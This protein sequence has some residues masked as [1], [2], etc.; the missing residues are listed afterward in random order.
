MHAGPEPFEDRHDLGGRVSV[1]VVGADADECDLRSD[2]GQEL[3]DGRS[4]A[5][6]RDRQQ[7]RAQGGG[8]TRQQ[9]RLRR[10]LDVARGEHTLAVVLD[11]QHDRGVVQLATG[12]AV[13]PSR[14]RMEHVD[15]QI[16]ERQRLARDRRADR[17]VG[18]TRDLEHLGRLG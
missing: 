5:M 18:L 11:P 14:R 3:R 1:P 7:L 6:V 13:R 16:P 8:I 10:D 15:P 17:D 9:V 12:P 2:G 4:R